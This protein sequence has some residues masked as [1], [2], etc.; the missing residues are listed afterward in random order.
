MQTI[1]MANERTHQ[2]KIMLSDEEKTW[3]E[4]IA[5][6]RGLTSSDVLRLYIRD[7][8]TTLQE[9]A[10]LELIRGENP[11][12]D[13]HQVLSCFAADVDMGFDL[14]DLSSELDRTGGRVRG[15]VGVLNELR[16]LDY[17]KRTSAGYQ[18]TTK[19]RAYV[20]SFW[21]RRLP[22]SQK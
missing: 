18:L 16:R 7:T 22:P 11:T 19:G 14:A 9:N 10:R 1:D 8:W 21:N 12:D 20:Q 2:F 17:L 13:Q 5:A 6:G 3:L 15:L 4:A